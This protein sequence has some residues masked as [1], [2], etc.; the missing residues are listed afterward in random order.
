MFN[1]SVSHRLICLSG[2]SKFDS[3]V[4]GVFHVMRLQSLLMEA[5]I[6][7]KDSSNV[8][9]TVNTVKSSHYTN[10]GILLYRD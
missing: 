3:L 9:I 1:Q 4:S 8:G 7:P 10:E 5:H 2:L 6:I